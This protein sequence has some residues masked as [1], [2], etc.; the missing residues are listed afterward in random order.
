MD[1]KALRS[2]IQKLIDKF[3]RVKADG[4]YKSYNEENTKKDFI[5][6]LFRALGWNVEDSEE[7]K[8]EEKVSKKRVDYAFRINGVPKFYLEAKPLREFISEPKYAKQAIE[9]A[10]NKSVT[11]AILC[12]FEGIRVFNAEWKWNDKQPMRNQFL[13]LRY[14]E[15]LG[16]CFKYLTWLS[17]ESFEEGVLDKQATILGKKVKK[18]PI[19][20]QLLTDFTEYRTFLSKDILKNNQKMDLSQEDLDEVVQRILD[21]IIFIRT[22]EDKE[23]ESE[24]L[25]SL[26][27]IYDDKE[28]RLHKE[29]N[30]RFREY[31]NGYNSKLFLEHLCEK[32]IVSNDALKQIISGTYRSKNLD[33][34]YDFSAIDA[35][36]LGNIY[37]QYL[38]HIL[39]ATS[40][41]AKITNGK[42]H[43]KEQGIYYT[44]TNV[45]DYIV[46]NTLGEELSKRGVKID[47]LRILDPA[48]G[49]GSFLLKTFDI[50]SEYITKK[51][52]KAQQTKFEDAYGDSSKILKRK[53]ELLRNCIYGVDLDPQAVEI[54]QLNLLLKLAEKR[55]RLPTLQENIKCGNSLI[56]DPE[57]IG[58]RAFKYEEEFKKI[59]E[60][61]GFDIVIG[62]PPYGADFKQNELKFLEKLKTSSIKNYDSYVFFVENT[63]RLLKEGGLFGFITPDTFL[64]KS[65]MITLRKIILDNFKIKSIAEVGAVFGEAKVT[66]NIIFIFEKCSSKKQLNKNKFIHK[67]LDK[68]RSKD[69]RLKLISE[70]KWDSEGQLLQKSWANSPEMRLGKFN[71]EKSLRIISKIDDKGTR[72]GDIEDV[73]IS[74]GSEGGKNLIKNK[75]IDD[76]YKPVVIPDDVGRYSLKFNDRYFPIINPHHKKYESEKILVIRIRNTK[77]KDRIIATYDDT[78]IF[79]LKT[80]QILNLKEDS[81]FDLKFFLGIL[82]SKLMNFYCRHYLSDDM[83]KRYLQGLKIILPEKRKDD[84]K[85]IDLVEKILSLNKKLNEIGFKRTD[86]TIRLEREIGIIDDKL[87]E[88]IYKLYGLTK[89]DISVVEKSL[90]IEN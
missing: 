54:A 6:P 67:T 24:K 13:D 79:N 32:V 77:L 90:S 40:K 43:R 60:S 15:Y 17:K 30:K 4:K 42:A 19:G 50:L 10:W 53:T 61:G 51:E 44:P 49:S 28:G 80:L 16:S 86:E 73:Q 9:Y 18:L 41:R 81:K 8:A 83:N 12:N 88:V 64:R 47:E 7:V 75:V 29:L 55:K 2:E 22:C 5:Q 11:W 63:I 87:N 21:R 46:R 31:D 56:D 25:E 72:I 59:M 14:N 26:I 89:E 3:E 39:K 48:C 23:I 69:E 70:N 85:I 35:D 57:I 65:E 68:D 52:G 71:D 37:E 36:V 82:N 33:I 58:N 38:G 1:E 84:K 74:R 76:S 20:Q 78:G 45:V 66:E 27:R 62:N 34:R